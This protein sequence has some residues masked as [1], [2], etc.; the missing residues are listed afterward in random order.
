[1][2]LNHLR[3]FTVIVKRGSF[4]RA[5][6]QL[7][8][9]QPALSNCVRKL[10][11]LFE[12]PLLERRPQ[13]VVPTVYGEAL[14]RFSSS[15]ISA[16]DR[17]S[18]EIENLKRGSRGHLRIGA[19]AG[20]LE[21]VVPV[22]I[23]EMNLNRPEFSFEVSFGYLNQLIEELV[24][25][26]HDFI[27]STYWP[28]VAIPESLVLEHI[29]KLSLSIY[30]RAEHPLASRE[31]IELDELLQSQWI[32]PD[33][34]GMDDFF[35][36]LTGDR[37]SGF[38]SRPIVSRDVNFI[39]ETMRQMDL[40]SLIPDYVARPFVDSGAFR[41]LAYDKASWDISAGLIYKRERTQTPAIQMFR[42]V[43]LE[44]TREILGL[45]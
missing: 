45:R 17:A 29:S 16:V 35:G 24:D 21:Q 41:R 13:G 39:H 44:K 36:K 27:L 9:S 11:E 31:S 37:H 1:M 15:A 32:A 25:D 26:R 23:A 20:I 10:E 38:L 33:S 19:P 30:A 5:A 2:N 3:Y 28:E 6:K 8:I 34:R 14:A 42:Q 4:Q 18:V 43:A 22:I 40:L 7:N 12:V